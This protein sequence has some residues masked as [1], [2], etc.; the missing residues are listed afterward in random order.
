M[1]TVPKVR[2]GIMKKWVGPNQFNMNILSWEVTVNVMGVVQFLHNNKEKLVKIFTKKTSMEGFGVI[3]LDRLY[4]EKHVFRFFAEHLSYPD[5]YKLY[6]KRG[7]S[8]P[9]SHPGYPHIIKYWNIMSQKSLDEIQSHYTE[10]F[11]FQKDAT[12]FMTYVKYEDS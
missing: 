8:L 10:I 12:L 1:Y 2:L 6:N 7:C 11:D 5:E 4:E 9:P 3:D